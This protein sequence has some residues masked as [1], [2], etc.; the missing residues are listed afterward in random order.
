MNVVS[1]Y[2]KNLDQWFSNYGPGN[3]G[4]GVGDICK[5]KNILI[6]ITSRLYLPFL[7]SALKWEYS[8]VFR[9]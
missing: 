2:Y 6:I 9:E 7:I 3:L 5:V 1:E 8:G 4:Q